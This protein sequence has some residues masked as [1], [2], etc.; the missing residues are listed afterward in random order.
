MHR[1]PAEIAAGQMWHLVLGDRRFV[2]GQGAHGRML[3]EIA[4]WRE[5]RLF[6]S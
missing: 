2:V 3:P 6:H 5:G 1:H 4:L